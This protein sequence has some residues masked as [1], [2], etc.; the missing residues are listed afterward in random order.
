MI[1]IGKGILAFFSTRLGKY[2]AVA[3]GVLILIGV[4]WWQITAYGARQYEAGQTDEKRWQAEQSARLARE[5]QNRA[6]SAT[7]A[8]N[9]SV[10][11]ADADIRRN[12]EELDR[13]TAN[14][15][16]ESPSA[17]RRARICRELREDARRRGVAA[18][19]C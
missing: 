15:P 1:A 12:R 17:R 13:E 8:R 2:A 11:N 16:D 14:L 10:A 6:N 19:A 18:P 3:L 5:L 7:D 9:R 4:I